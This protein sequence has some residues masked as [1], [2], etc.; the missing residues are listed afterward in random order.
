VVH[1]LNNG[2]L[3]RIK[4]G[5]AVFILMDEIKA[6]LETEKESDVISPEVR[7]AESEAVITVASKVG[8]SPSRVQEQYGR[9][10][11]RPQP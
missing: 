2:K 6:L 9:D 1:F 7:P 10:Q 11:R 4:E 8:D 5:S 3:A